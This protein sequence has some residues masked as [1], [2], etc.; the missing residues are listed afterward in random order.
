MRFIEMMPLGSIADFQVESI[1]TADEMRARIQAVYGELIPLEW[2]GHNPARPDPLPGGQGTLGFI[3]SVSAPFCEGCD[4]VRLTSDGRLRL[5]LLRDDEVDLLTPIR[6]GASD[7]ELRDLI[8]GGIYNKPWGHGLADKI[9]A[10]SRIMSQ[11]GG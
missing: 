5:C 9:I 2:D 1:V 11:I 6:D 3:S 4:R 7:A 8:G 10:G